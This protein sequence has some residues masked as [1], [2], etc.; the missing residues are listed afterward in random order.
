MFK[1]DS[2]HALR[3]GRVHAPRAGFIENSSRPPCVV[4]N[5]GAG[6]AGWGRL[7]RLGTLLGAP[8]GV[9]WGGWGSCGG[10][11]GEV[12]EA[13]HCWRHRGLGIRPWGMGA[14]SI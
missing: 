5:L 6:W 12:G 10:W 13:G 11:L 7:G 4:V 9:A 14:L 1:T 3:A 2:V 8:G